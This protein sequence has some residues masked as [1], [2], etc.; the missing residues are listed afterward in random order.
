MLIGPT[1]TLATLE[2]AI[3][4]KRVELKQE[5]NNLFNK[6]EDLQMTLRT[7]PMR[8]TDGEGKLVS[9]PEYVNAFEEFEGTRA[10][11]T[12]VKEQ[13]DHMKEK[14]NDLENIEEDAKSVG[15][16]FVKSEERITLTLI[17]AVRYGVTQDMIDA[18][19]TKK[20][21]A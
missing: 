10:A 6:A 8:T 7:V 11:I 5:E 19:N 14:A 17:E 13:L 2:D 4:K 12:R 15:K 1:I 3:S 21:E 9:N 20:G 18:D 16:H